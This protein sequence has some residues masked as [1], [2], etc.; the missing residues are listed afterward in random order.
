M[1][2]KGRSQ[3]PRGL[4]PLACWD[5][6]FESHWGHGCLSVV[7]VVCCQVEV[8]A[9]DWSLVQGS[10]T[11]CGASL[12]VIKKPRTR[13]GYSPARGLQ[14]T[15]PQW[16][17]APVEKKSGRGRGVDHPSPSSAEVKERVELYIYSPSGLAWSVLGWTL[18][19]L[20]VGQENLLIGWE[21]AP[22]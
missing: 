19:L 6:G 17:V 12:C 13:E 10:P 1:P 7:S 11:D 9:T 22:V 15:N 8:F 16:V 14:N 18:S 20:S 2:K 21:N 3:W 5:R 4:R